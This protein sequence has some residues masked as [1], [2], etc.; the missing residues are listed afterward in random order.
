MR[1]KFLFAFCAI[2]I[3]SVFAY[4]LTY[5][6]PMPEEW[7]SIRAGESPE[8]V[9]SHLQE[10]LFTDMRGEKG[11]DIATREYSVCWIFKCRNQMIINYDEQR[12]RVTDVR[13]QRSDGGYEYLVKS[14]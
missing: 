14:D 11:F 5:C 6:P 13:V 7:K 10:K 3:V 9:Q 2:F 8:E 1:K 4:I 12:R